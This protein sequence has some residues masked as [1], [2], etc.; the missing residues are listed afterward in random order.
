[1]NVGNRMTSRSLIDSQIAYYDARAQEYESSVNYRSGNFADVD[2]DSRALGWMQKFVRAMPF[3]SSTLELGC[4]TGIWTRELMRT[5]SQLT[6][7]DSSSQMLALNRRACGDA[8]RYECGSI[9][10]WETSQRFDRIAAAFLLSHVPDDHLTAFV[11]KIHH[12]NTDVG[13]VLLIDEAEPLE[14]VSENSETIRELADGQR[15]AIVKICRSADQIC[16]SFARA[17]Y[18]SNL[19]LIAGRFVAIVL[20]RA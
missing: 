17:D 19:K 6:A 16:E 4:G 2:E 18:R 20:T 11:D 8:V 3:V 9:F 10:E 12:W 13:E 15:F 14:D 7:L 1:M 5:S